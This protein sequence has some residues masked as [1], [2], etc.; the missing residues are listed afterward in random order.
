[1]PH[2]QFKRAI[3][4]GNRSLEIPSKNGLEVLSEAVK[5]QPDIK[6]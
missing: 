2:L 5:S 4:F 1:M 6:I 3:R